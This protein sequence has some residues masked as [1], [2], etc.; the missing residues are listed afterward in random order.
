MPEVV[1]G[2][3]CPYTG[4]IYHVGDEYDGEHFEEMQGKG[5]IAID[6]PAPASKPREGSKPKKSK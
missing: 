6:G 5:Y 3:K 2:F 4:R 1:S